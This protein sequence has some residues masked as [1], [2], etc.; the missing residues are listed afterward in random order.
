MEISQLIFIIDVFKREQYK[1][2]ARSVG[3][4]ALFLF[5]HKA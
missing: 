4:R 2:S 3:G 5:R 1:V